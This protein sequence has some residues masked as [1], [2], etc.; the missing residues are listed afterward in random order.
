MNRSLT[1]LFRA[2][3]RRLRVAWALTTL[4]LVA[5]LVALAALTLVVVA[6]YFNL[7]WAELAAVWLTVGSA[8][9]IVAYAVVCRVPDILVARAA[10][11]GLRTRDAFA[12]SVELDGR[13]DDFA[14]R[15]HARARELAAV[16]APSEAVRFRLLR[17]P[18]AIAAIMS[19]L[20]WIM[21]AGPLVVA[22][23]GK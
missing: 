5:P 4:Q 14:D 6:R 9:M 3:R 23:F 1:P 21:I 12:T 20:C 17:K 8:V 13:D 16:S 11:R 7:P 18:V 19:S 10:D 15:V 2:V 22:W